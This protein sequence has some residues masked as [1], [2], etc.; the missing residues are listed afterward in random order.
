[1]PF[2]FLSIDEFQDERAHAHPVQQRKTLHT[3][4]ENHCAL[5]YRVSPKLSRFVLDCPSLLIC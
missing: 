5:A 1:M 2:N 4:T 3:L